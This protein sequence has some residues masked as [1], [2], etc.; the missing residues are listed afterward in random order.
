MPLVRG[1]LV[2]STE[3]TQVRECARVLIQTSG[4]TVD[5]IGREVLARKLCRAAR[6][7]GGYLRKQRRDQRKGRKRGRG[8]TQDVRTMASTPI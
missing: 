1:N 7:E 8:K 3:N 5:G 6:V 4:L 2:S